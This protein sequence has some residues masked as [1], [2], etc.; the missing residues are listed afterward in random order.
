MRKIAP[1]ASSIVLTDKV[2]EGENLSQHGV[3]ELVLTPM[4]A[5][6]LA[7]KI[8]MMLARRELRKEKEKICNLSSKVKTFI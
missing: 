7:D 6:N 2:D 8:L 3:N 4:S 1:E 5:E